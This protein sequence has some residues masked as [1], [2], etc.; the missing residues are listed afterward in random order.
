MSSALYQTDGRVLEVRPSNG[1]HW[2]RE[3]LTALV[4]GVPEVVRTNDDRFM[5][6]NDAHQLL[7][8]EPNYPATRLY[9]RGRKEPICGPAVVVD[10]RLEIDGP[11]KEDLENWAEMYADIDERG[12]RE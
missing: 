3:E 9:I 6:V 11:A 12:T 10:T 2:T 1:L 5:V 7:E 4:G 8:L